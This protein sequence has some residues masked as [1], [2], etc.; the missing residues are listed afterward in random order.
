M[1]MLVNLCERITG[2]FQLTKLGVRLHMEDYTIKAILHDYSSKPVSEGAFEMLTVWRG[3]TNDDKEA[4]QVLEKA[5]R[6]MDEVRMLQD[7]MG[8]QLEL[9]KAQNSGHSTRS[10]DVRF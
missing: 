6:E 7:V 2:R 10:S 9:P 8:V 5:L 4:F 3:R 1:E